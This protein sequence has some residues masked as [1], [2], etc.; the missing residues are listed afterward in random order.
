MTYYVAQ[1]AVC[2]HGNENSGS[3]MADNFLSA[4]ETA[5]LRIKAD[6]QR[7]IA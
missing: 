2:G 5:T 7:W 1:L 3:T 4:R 6:P